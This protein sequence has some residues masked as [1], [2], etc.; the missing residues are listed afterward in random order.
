V[1][2]LGLAGGAASSEPASPE[3][4]SPEPASQTPTSADAVDPAAERSVPDLADERAY[5]VRPYA[6]TGGRTRSGGRSPLPVEAL[7][8]TLDRPDVAGL[9]PEERRI[10]R[11]TDG[12][13][14]SVAELSAALEV[15]VGVV[16]VLVGDLE[17]SGRVRVHGPASLGSTPATS[18]SVLESVL[19][20]ICAL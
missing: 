14:L 11:L 4:A 1:R 6:L 15:P 10:L 7:V 9:S 18:L 2:R 12:Q 5:A 16:R 20:G 13:F 8:Q 3:P 19:D 17:A